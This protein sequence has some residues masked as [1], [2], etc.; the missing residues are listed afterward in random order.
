MRGVPIKNPHGLALV[1]VQV[2]R[3][4][5]V[6][7]ARCMPLSVANK[8]RVQ[9]IQRNGLMP[10]WHQEY[11]TRHVGMPSWHANGLNELEELVSASLWRGVA[12]PFEYPTF[13]VLSTQNLPPRLALC[14][15]QH[16][17]ACAK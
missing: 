15:M 16:P 2:R 14:D 4:T 11:R 1:R 8:P 17:P 10:S 5:P 12:T 3:I 13:R 6:L 7:V 9:R